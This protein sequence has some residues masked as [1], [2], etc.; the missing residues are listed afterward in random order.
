[1]GRLV[2]SFKETLNDIQEDLDAAIAKKDA[3]D[4]GHEGVYDI[5]YDV[6]TDHI[7]NLYT[8]LKSTRA[9]YI[10]QKKNLLKKWGKISD[11]KLDE[12]SQNLTNLYA[13]RDSMLG[14]LLKAKQ[15]NIISSIK[16]LL[17]QPDLFIP[18]I[19]PNSTDLVNP[20]N[21]ALSH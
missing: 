10:S 2:H 15:N 18:L 8:E 14:S 7:R 3:I 9:D 16:G 6:L 11:D 19:I 21:A 17:E 1:M 12:L 5:D 13:E 4:N 20:E